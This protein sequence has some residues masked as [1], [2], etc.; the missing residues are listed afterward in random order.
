[1]LRHAI[2][3]G[4]VLTAAAMAALAPWPTAHGEQRSFAE[5]ERGRYL[6]AAGDCQACHTAKDGTP[7]AGGRPIETPFGVIYSPN[8]TPDRDTGIGAWSDDQFYR[9]LHEGIAADGDYLYP[10]FP[11][12]WYTKVTREDADAIRAFLDTLPP[13]RNKRPEN[14]LAW[15]LNNREV[16]AGWNELFFNP[17]TFVP[18]A[19]KSAEWNRGAYLVE[20]LGHCGACH[21]PTNV[22]GAAEKTS[23]LQ[24]GTLQDWYAPSLAGDL[25]T[26]LGA[27]R[28]D[29]ITA[30]LKTGHNART[31][32]YGPMSEVVT[33]TT[34]KLSDADVAA[35]AAYLKDMPAGTSQPQPEKPDQ[36]I[37]RSGE[38]IYVDNCSACHRMNGEG[39]SGMFPSLKGDAVV[40][41]S[42]ATTVVRLV[43]SGGRSVPT[44]SRP[45]SLS[46]P[47]FGWKLSDEQIADVVS[48]V[49]SAWGNSASPVSASD[50]SALRNQISMGKDEASH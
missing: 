44:A 3:R 16:M 17:G 31:A 12:P 30:F 45:T 10:A 40:Q 41:S 9:A 8:I 49:R 38:A 21:T 15:P 18:D 22:F 4:A 39:V 2:I 25:R 27:W 42:K 43:L 1:M 37:A 26:G 28:A 32:A 5:V 13:T 11:Y 29:E 46:M 20:G 23:R 7:F 36:S 19:T 34:S 24:G 33:F 6:T 35:I 47:S 48:Y 50:V 14:Q